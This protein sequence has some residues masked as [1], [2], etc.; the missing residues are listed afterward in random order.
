MSTE[1]PLALSKESKTL[2]TSTASPD[3]SV[4]QGTIIS[5]SNA[6]ATL[7]LIEEYGNTVEPLT[8]EGEKRLKWKLYTRLISL[9]LLINLWLFVRVV[10]P[11]FHLPANL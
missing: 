7:R 9:L 3:E 8:P 5:E 6:D 4:G 11:R 2:T 1:K 10:R